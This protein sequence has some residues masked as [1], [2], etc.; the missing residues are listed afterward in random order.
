MLLTG[1][2]TE[3][4]LL[5]P[6]SASSRVNALYQITIPY[7]SEMQASFADIRF[8]DSDGSQLEQYRK[9]YTSGVESVWIF[10]IP[11]K[12]AAGKYIYVNSGRDTASLLSDLVLSLTDLMDEDNVTK[13]YSGGSGTVELENG[14]WTLT[15][16]DASSTLFTGFYSKNSMNANANMVGR[17]KLTGGAVYPQVAVFGWNAGQYDVGS[18][19]VCYR[20]VNGIYWQ[21]NDGSELDDAT[22]M[23][24]DTWHTIEIKRSNTDGNKAKFYF[25]GVYELEL[26]HNE[27]ANNLGVYVQVARYTVLQVADLIMIDSDVEDLGV[28]EILEDLDLDSG[29]TQTSEVSL[30]SYISE[31]KHDANVVSLV[32][33]LSSSYLYDIANKDIKAAVALLSGVINQRYK[34]IIPLAITDSYGAAHSGIS[35]ESGSTELTGFSSLTEDQYKNAVVNVVESD[36]FYQAKISENDET[37]VTITL[38]SDLP[39]LSSAVVFVSTNNDGA[40]AGYTQKRVMHLA[41]PVWGVWDGAGRPITKIDP[42]LAPNIS[43][44]YD[45]NDKVYWYRRGENIVLAFGSGGCTGGYI[46]VGV[47]ALP[48][49]ISSGS[50]DIDFPVEYRDI[51]QAMSA[52][53]ILTKFDRKEEAAHRIGY[54]IDLIRGITGRAVDKKAIEKAVAA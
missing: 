50:D 44:L 22:A 54:A 13:Y 2:T 35:H 42:D 26:P 5:I 28:Y 23:G 48:N 46:L 10:V 11:N 4:Q 43:Q 18:F 19:E 30:N 49:D 1:W 33:K 15:S 39:V 27:A 6:A 25:D 12:P 29:T 32:N 41:N 52:A 24:D 38:G 20:T 53:R 37:T 21:S 36:I 9:E 16:G 7:S 8:V 34:K 14:V 47:Y 45:F 31:I 40:V 51:P 17:F 3:Y